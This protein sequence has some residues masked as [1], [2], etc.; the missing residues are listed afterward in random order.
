[1]FN[2]NVLI[3]GGPGQPV[4]GARSGFTASLVRHGAGAADVAQA[5]FLENAWLLFDSV[6]LPPAGIG[7]LEGGP[8]R[9][10][11]GAFANRGLPAVGIQ[12]LRDGQAGPCA[13]EDS[14]ASGGARCSGQAGGIGSAAVNGFFM[15]N[16][17]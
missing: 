4:R 11:L 15:A 9:L 7:C 1:M 17:I 8:S 6:S 16:F 13:G 5:A 14:S 2:I 3:T 10:D 12:A